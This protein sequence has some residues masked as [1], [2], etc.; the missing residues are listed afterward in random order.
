[1]TPKASLARL[2]S[3]AAPHWAVD[4]HLTVRQLLLVSRAQV[5]H[6]VNTAMVQTYWRI[7]RVMV[8]SQQSGEP[9]GEGFEQRM[10]ELTRQ[11]RAEFGDGFSAQSLSDYAQFY[12]TFPSLSLLRKNL[13]WAHYKILLGIDKHHIRQ[14]Y[15]KEAA[16][17]GWSVCELER[18]IASHYHERL[19]HPQ[20]KFR[21]QVQTRLA[22][23]IAQG[24]L[25]EL[26][27]FMRDPYVLEFLGAQGEPALGAHAP[28]HSLLD[29]WQKFFLDLDKGFALVAQQ[30]QLH[31]QG[32]PDCVD[33]VFYNVLLK[34]FVLVNMRVGEPMQPGTATLNNCLH[35]FDAQHRLAGNNPSLGLILGLDGH[36]ARARY[37]PQDGH[38]PGFASQCQTVLPTEAELQ[39]ELERYRAL[40]EMHCHDH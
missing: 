13:R 16:E 37:L 29:Q 23:Y 25:P 3:A 8:E 19:L 33:L 26:I 2:P 5:R 35:A 36:A 10:R 4:L 30:K 34:C 38:D 11:L 1:M 40:L 9:V 21:V 12:L 6:S 32:K 14:W 22:Q 39:A 15:A 24:A 28:Q 20:D 27:H 18:Q 31:V 7:G 17:R